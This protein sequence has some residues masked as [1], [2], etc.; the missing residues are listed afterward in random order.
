[1]RTSGH[2]FPAAR[3]RSRPSRGTASKRLSN[4]STRQV[5][6]ATIRS[7]EPRVPSFAMDRPVLHAFVDELVGDERL[8]A[9]AG[10]LPTRARVS[11]SALPVLLASLHELLGRGLVCALPED[12]DARDAA[13]AAAWFLGEERVALLPS[14]GVHWASGLEPP[15]HLVGERAR[16]LDVLAGGGL[17]CAS[18]TALA[19]GM[20]P[21][22]ERPAPIE[23]VQGQEPGIDLLAE[24]FALSGYE[25]VERVEERGQFA[26]RGG[27]VD[28]FPTT[29]REPLRIELFGDEIE[30]IRAFSPFTQRA[31]HPVESATVYPAA[32]RRPDLSEPTLPDDD[33]STPVV[34]TDLVPPLEAAPDLVW[35][36]DEV[37]SVALEELNVELNLEGSTELDPLP[38]NQPFSFEAQRPA[39]AA[40]GLAEAENELGALVRA[41]QRVVVAF[42][43]RGEALRTQNLLRRIE[44]R[45][46]EPGERLPDDAELLFAVA[47]ARRGFV[48]RELGLVLLPDTQVFRKRRARAA[49]V[50]RALQSFADLR[51]GDYVVH[52]DHGVGQLQTFETKEVA[53]VTRDYL[54][55]AFRGEDRLYVPHEQIGKVSRYVGA[56]AK[57]PALSKLGG[58]AWANP[59]SR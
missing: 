22:S 3:M 55:L 35:E 38:A 10:A 15:P 31:L 12:A 41:G 47:P 27:L 54:L 16:A 40:R 39:L 53:G 33:E 32:E 57:A 58:K 26:V 18:A 1:M 8:S 21:P 42:P 45:L 51:T 37:R 4:G 48:W 9:F 23:V 2:S 28:V 49:G 17:V 24:S 6:P 30:S 19:E 44:A 5:A 36:P 50:G 34:P 46:L 20:P 59:K 13:D 25:R 11:E 7:A 52:E 43:H 14:R 29:G 56:D